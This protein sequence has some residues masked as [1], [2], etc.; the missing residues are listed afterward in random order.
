MWFVEMRDECGRRELNPHARGHWYLKPACLPFHHFRVCLNLRS[1]SK[2]AVRVTRSLGYDAN[3][4]CRCSQSEVEVAHQ[5]R[6]VT[7]GLHVVEGVLNSSGSRDD[8]SRSNISSNQLAVQLLL[9]PC[10]VLRRHSV[11]G[12]R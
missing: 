6:D 2:P 8:E 12:V 4:R 7:G 3:C 9:T 5:F 1:A 11:I 10:S